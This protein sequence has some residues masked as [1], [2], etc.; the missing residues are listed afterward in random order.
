MNMKKPNI[1]IGLVGV[2]IAVLFWG[3]AFPV[4]R[5]AVQRFDPLNLVALRFF[6]ASSVLLVFALLSK[7]IRRPDTKDIPLLLAQGIL[8]ISAYHLLLSWGQLTIPAGTASLL[9]ASSPCIAS[10]LA[11]TFLGEPLSRQGWLGMLVGFS[12]VS[13]IVIGQGKD[14]SLAFSSVLILI[15]A[16]SQSFYYI[17]QR[18]FFSKY[19]P[20][21]LACYT[22]WGGTL[23]M[24]LFLKA[25]ASLE[26]SLTIAYLG[27][28]PAAF[29][30]IAWTYAL[31]SFSTARAS[32]FLYL[33]PVVAIIVGWL[34]LNEKPTLL[35]VVGG[36]IIMTGVVLVNDA[37][38]L[39]IK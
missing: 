15:A 38:G 12:G 27:I 8:G 6:I 7:K 11:A 36:G 24:L 26:V 2:V 39:A 9:N 13:L 3:S 21:E 25:P 29:A 10:F 14:F 35:S 34:W 30:Y 23:P 18:P 19:S 32:S 28:F 4:V 20:L 1:S 5:Y 22:L 16:F 33:V 17:L 31:A 37:K